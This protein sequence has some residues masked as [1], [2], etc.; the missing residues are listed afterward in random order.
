MKLLP[1]I[2]VENYIYILALEIASRGNQPALCRLYRHTFVPYT[3][4]HAAAGTHGTGARR[5]AA[6]ASSVTFTAAV[7]G[8][9]QINRS[10]CGSRPA[11]HKTGHFGDV[12]PSQTLGLVSKKNTKP[13]TRKSTHSP[14]KRNVPQHKINTKKL[15]PGLVAF[16][17]I[18]P[19]NGAGLFSKKKR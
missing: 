8:W 4:R 16:Y 19:G 15:K 5:A 2:S 1:C 6:N 13:N 3:G 14:I 9:T 10:C 12:T 18:R 7:E 11:R 17:H